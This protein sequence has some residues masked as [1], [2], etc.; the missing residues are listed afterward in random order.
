M[1]IVKKNGADFHSVILLRGNPLDPNTLLPSIEDLLKISPKIFNILEDYNYGQNSVT[2]HFLKNY[3]RYMWKTSLKTIEKRKQIIPC[4]SGQSSLVIWGNGDVSSCEELSPIG[5]IKEKNI[6]E[7]L[8]STEFNQ[9]LKS[10]KNKECHC[11]HNC[12]MLTSIFFNP[13]TWPNIIY[14]KKP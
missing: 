7:V 3:H 4:L 8:K 9:Q 1:K 11:T 2:A 12:A 10:I 14:Q 5:N 13:K 6:N